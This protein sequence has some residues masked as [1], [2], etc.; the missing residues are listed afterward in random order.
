MIKRFSILIIICFLLSGC[1]LFKSKNKCADCPS[2]KKQ[3]GHAN[4]PTLKREGGM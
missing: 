3:K 4:A 1:Y 2:W